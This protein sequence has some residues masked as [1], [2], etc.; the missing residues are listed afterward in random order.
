MTGERKTNKKKIDPTRIIEDSGR[1]F[2]FEFQTFYFIRG[3]A[4]VDFDS[5]RKY[6]AK[7][8]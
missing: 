8:G 3:R 1:S 4:F 2:R 7:L 6:E 5:V